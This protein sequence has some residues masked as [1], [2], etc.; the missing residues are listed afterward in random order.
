MAAPTRAAEGKARGVDQGGIS[1]AL[2]TTR[3]CVGWSALPYV[4][5]G[6]TATRTG[7]HA[8][9][10]FLVT[11]QKIVS[12]GRG[13]DRPVLQQQ[14]VVPAGYGKLRPTLLKRCSVEPATSSTGGCEQI[15]ARSSN[16]PSWLSERRRKPAAANCPSAVEEDPAAQASKAPPSTPLSRTVTVKRSTPCP[17]T[18]TVKL[19]NG[20]L[21]AAAAARATRR[22]DARGLTCVAARSRVGRDAVRSAPRG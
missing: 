9:R 22:S 13:H 8:M 21:A 6:S 17:V 18:L 10:T 19:G 4:V 5:V 12:D 15:P 2:N 1:A 7:V 14:T 3:R 16:S 20:S 11:F